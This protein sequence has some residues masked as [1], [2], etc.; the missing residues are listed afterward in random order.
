MLGVAK[1]LESNNAISPHAVNESNHT[2]KD[3][4]TQAS[5]EKRT[6]LDIDLEEPGLVVRRSQGLFWF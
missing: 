1:P 2:W 5:D 4:N 6:V 3:L